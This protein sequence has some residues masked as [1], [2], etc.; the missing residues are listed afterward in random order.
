MVK[1]RRTTPRNELETIVCRR[2]KRSLV[3]KTNY[4]I[5][6]D[7]LLDTNGYMSVCKYCV[8]EITN[9]F[10][11]SERDWKKTFLLACKAFNVIYDDVFV[12][13]T[14]EVFEKFN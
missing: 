7:T 4:Y 13:K 3:A 9:S 12:Q 5:S 1:L 2:C 10:Y 8:N 11:S 14:I 6:F